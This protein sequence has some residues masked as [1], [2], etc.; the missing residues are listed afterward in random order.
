M[1][2]YVDNF[3]VPARV[4]RLSARW[5]HL[6]ADT[7]EELHAFADR[8]ALN[9]TWFQDKGDGRWHYDVTDSKREQAIKL[10][11]QAIDIRD[12]GVFVSAR[13][14]REAGAK[15][16]RCGTGVPLL[17]LPQGDRDAVAAFEASLRIPEGES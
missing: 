17:A 8:L 14:K 9:R 13:C 1:T 2:V 6:T 7:K 12:M 5:S 10:G 4:G 11:A 15:P 16:I 3:R